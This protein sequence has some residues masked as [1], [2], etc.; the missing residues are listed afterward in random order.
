MDH[1]SM[2]LRTYGH[3]GMLR[4]QRLIAENEIVGK[5]DI[6]AGLDA[7]TV[8]LD[9]P[10]TDTLSCIGDREVSDH[11]QNF[12]CIP[13]NPKIVLPNSLKVNNCEIIIPN[14]LAMESRLVK[15]IVGKLFDF[16]RK[17]AYV[18]QRTLKIGLHN[19]HT[20]VG[21][22]F[23]SQT[24]ITLHEDEEDYDD[25]ILQTE[26]DHFNVRGYAPHELMGLCFVLEYEIAIPHLSESN[27]SA[28]G[29]L[30]TM[31]NIRDNN[32][33]TSVICGAA[34]YNPFDEKM[35]KTL[36]KNTKH[37]DIE[38]QFFS[39]DTCSIL[40]PKPVF[41]DTVKYDNRLDDD[42]ED[43]EENQ[44]KKNR[45]LVQ[46][47]MKVEDAEDRVRDSVDKMSTGAGSDEDESVVDHHDDRYDS[48]HDRHRTR[49]RTAPKSPHRHGHSGRGHT[50]PTRV[51]KRYVEQDSDSDTPASPLKLDSRYYLDK[52]PGRDDRM[53]EMDDE[54]AYT[55]SPADSPL[56]GSM[57]SFPPQ[58]GSLYHRSLNA[59]LYSEEAGVGAQ[60]R[61]SQERI[62]ADMRPLYRSGEPA[63]TRLQPH[64]ITNTRE[65]SRASRA[66]LDRHGFMDIVEDDI[67][68]DPY[69]ALRASHKGKEKKGGRVSVHV[70]VNDPLTIN[71]IGIQFAAFRH[72]SSDSGAYRPKSVYFSYQFFSTAATRTELL[73]L[74]PPDEQRLSVFAREDSFHRNEPPLTLRHVI[75]CSDQTTTEGIEFAE[76][77]AY[78]IL[79]IDVWDAD[80]LILIGTCAVPLRE[81]MRQGT[82]SL[83][84]AV[85]V[86]VVATDISNPGTSADGGA[87]SSVVYS[88]GVLNGPVAGSVQIIFNNHGKVGKI[89]RADTDTEAP[90]LNWRLKPTNGDDSGSTGRAKYAT[91]AKPL[92]S[93]APDLNDAL[94]KYRQSGMGG[95]R[96]M[97]KARGD[98]DANSLSGDDLLELFKL[99]K[100]KGESGYV[101]YRG[102][103][104]ALMEVASMDKLLTKLLENVHEEK[105][106]FVD[107]LLAFQDENG[108]IKTRDFQEALVSFM[109][110]CHVKFSAEEAAVLARH[111]GKTAGAGDADQIGTQELL[112][113]CEMETKNQKWKAS[114]NRF[115]LSVHDCILVNIDIEQLMAEFDL[116]GDGKIPPSDFKEVLRSVSKHSKSLLP[117]DIDVITRHF[118]IVIGTRQVVDLKE[119]MRNLG[120]NY[121]GNLEAILAKS[122]SEKYNNE[123]II[124]SIGKNKLSY[125][126]M[127]DALARLGVFDNSTLKHEQLKHIFK[128]IDFASSGK[129]DVYSLLQHIKLGGVKGSDAKSKKESAEELLNTLIERVHAEG[130]DIAKTFMHFD[131]NGD[132]VITRMELQ[133]GLSNLKIFS[134]ISNWEAQIPALVWK[135]DKNG[136]NTIELREFFLHF[137]INQYAPNVAQKMTKVF[138]EALHQGSFNEVSQIFA[139]FDQDKNGV[140]DE[141]ELIAGLQAIGTFGTVTSTDAQEVISILNDGDGSNRVSSDRFVNFFRE[142][143]EDWNKQQRTVLAN[144]AMTALIKTCKN[145][146]KDTGKALRIIFPRTGSAKVN[147]NEFVGALK[148]NEH[149][150]AFAESDLAAILDLYCIEHPS[151]VVHNRAQGIEEDLF[152]YDIAEVIKFIDDKDPANMVIVMDPAESM[153]KLRM[154]FKKFS[155]DNGSTDSLFGK[156]AALDIH[157]FVSVVEELSSKYRIEMLHAEI[158]HVVEGLDKS[159]LGVVSLSD[160]KRLI[161]SSDE[162]KNSD[163]SLQE[164]SATARAISSAFSSP[165]QDS[166]RDTM[167]SISRHYEG[168]EGLLADMDPDSTGLISLRHILS[169]MN[170]EGAFT[171]GRGNCSKDLAEKILSSMCLK[172]DSSD[173][174]KIPTLLRFMENKDDLYSQR[175]NA[176]DSE[177]VAMDYEFHR[178]PV[179]HDLERKLRRVGRSLAK[180]GIDVEGMFS[181]LDRT[182]T[183][184]VQRTEFVSLLSEMG[185][186][187]IGEGFDQYNQKAPFDTSK[188]PQEYNQQLSQIKRI[189]GPGNIYAEA[190][191]RFANSWHKETKKY[192]AYHSKDGESK[193]GG[194]NQFDEAL[195][196]M[197]IIS[198]YRQ[199]QKKNLLQRVL[200]QSLVSNVNI[201]PRFAKTVFFEQA[202]TNPFNFEERFVIE[203]NDPE[204]RLVTN[205]QEWLYLRENVHASGSGKLGPD[206][207][208]IDMFDKD[209]YGNFNVALLPHETIYLPFT[210]MTLVPHIDQGPGAAKKLRLSRGESKGGEGKEDVANSTADKPHRVAKISIQSGSRGHLVGIV[211]VNVYPRSHVVNRTLRFLEVENSMMKRRVQ[212]VNNKAYNIEDTGRPAKYLHCVD[213][214]GRTSQ[215]NLVVEWS[216]SANANGSLDI[217]LRYRC[218]TFPQFGSFYIILYDDQYHSVQHEVSV[219]SLC[220]S[221]G[222]TTIT[223]TIWSHH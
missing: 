106:V 103:L 72:R 144:K 107:T 20:I 15:G 73:K 86:D 215:S 166:F 149:F 220:F 4:M 59:P 194:D 197:Q 122:L 50:S 114:G 96:S 110:R 127:E 188:D 5:H 181:R 206:P 68:V 76:Y 138:T 93:V 145:M 182:N 131:Q 154:I 140:M 213:H 157:T 13:V 198:W 17:D 191:P 39:D 36:T 125:G 177:L 205:L 204:L 174:V 115:R 187:M 1:A 116:D 92:S 216:P 211:Q 218:G 162:N 137:G 135:L 3:R 184:T 80:S 108:H 46:F 158:E 123:E 32:I 95:P 82:S 16:P 35:K 47:T 40:S 151:F 27:Y 209:A 192:D 118:T 26:K 38:L 142:R 53:A 130:I 170:S 88:G 25:D 175:E 143:V 167:T 23:D 65:L 12:F 24:L 30:Q 83:K 120:R 51:G 129:L 219:P 207:V 155:K 153:M 74:L 165:E 190:A 193:D 54:P 67:A 90:D 75:D 78:S 31:S 126:D 178:D 201:F 89:K 64:D 163:A 84:R 77:L 169:I 43:E 203:L 199:S 62:S 171:D 98:Q 132:G 121:V 71:D 2:S 196:S 104:M 180:Q 18:H 111:I 109:K 7:K 10:G 139:V 21:G 172:G 55:R 52:R 148:Q 156:E 94:S 33:V 41:V 128:K 150:N 100:A 85:E 152:L 79:Y 28:Q 212:F 185:M 141:E 102:K 173:M 161:L 91:R 19:G 58:T 81:L 49:T 214:D 136:D 11:K 8:S 124:A 57:S 63:T 176:D 164:E 117:E 112:T 37:N 87:S 210:F 70:E 99:F 105:D 134:S 66:R 60:I 61:R 179:I 223:I 186:H 56:R 113:Y 168:V 45:M 202:F 119:V 133:E 101:Q 22:E 69:L 48:D 147:R 159:K 195:E 44:E 34:V 222:P 189:R 200:S 9:G 97:N 217:I 14:R 29:M 208:E 42:D 160:F 183:G 221:P 6:V 146:K